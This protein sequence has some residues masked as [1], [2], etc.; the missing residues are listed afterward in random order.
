M[1]LVVLWYLVLRRLETPFGSEWEQ[2]RRNLRLPRSLECEWSRTEGRIREPPAPVVHH[3]RD[4][5]AS[6]EGFGYPANLYWAA[7]PADELHELFAV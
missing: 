3:L 2:S 5:R 1:S 6:A 7:A 4:T